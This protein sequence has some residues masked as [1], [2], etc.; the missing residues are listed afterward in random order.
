MLRQVVSITAVNLLSIGRRWGSTLTM[1][2]GV[3]AASGV[4]AG[5]HAFI[6]GFDDSLTGGARDI[7]AIVL[8]DGARDGGDSYLTDEHIRAISVADG[9]EKT[10]SGEPMMTRDAFVSITMT[11]KEDNQPH[12]VVVAAYSSALLRVRP[13]IHV[14]EGRMFAPGQRE[15]IVGKQT[16]M[17]FHHAAIGD[18]I[19][20]ESGNVRIVG[21]FESG[22]WAD[23][24]VLMD[25]DVL[26]DEYKR[27]GSNMVT[28]RLTSPP[29]IDALKSSLATNASLR[30]QVITEPEYYVRFRGTFSVFD[31][32]ADVVG[33]MMALGAVFCALNAMYTSVAARQREI[34][35]VRAMGFTTPSI[36][37]SVVVESVLVSAAGA[38]LGVLMAWLFFDGL[39]VTTGTYLMSVIHSVD[40]SRSVI[41]QSML[42]A[43][44]IGLVGA[45]WP[46]L[47]AARQP[48]SRAL[49]R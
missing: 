11:S 12:G 31:N 28:A 18:D 17:Q 46:S 6:A 2:I 26:L 22:F 41:Y 14:I 16:R 9:I 23:S 25:V 30:F 20:L 3:A 42:W 36:V 49:G 40:V 7:R 38:S 33:A 47:Q 21:V 29:A 5:M 13:E 44:A 43:C 34:A 15:A 4:F 24:C 32:V 19:P 35:I 39:T 27:V 10:A 1:L 48:V 45:L 8:G 37:V